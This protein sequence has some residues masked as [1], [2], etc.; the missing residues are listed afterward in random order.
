MADS[1]DKAERLGADKDEPEGARYIKIS[2]TLA[3]EISVN[4]RF[5]AAL[6]G[7]NRDNGKTSVP[8]SEGW[9]CGAWLADYL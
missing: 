7:I 2:D 4:I 9:D 1:L 5:A 3:R 6:I 8:P